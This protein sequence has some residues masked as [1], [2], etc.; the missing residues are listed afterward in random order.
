MENT[1][2]R[3]IAV[4]L[5]DKMFA[6][7]GSFTISLQKTGDVID[8]LAGRPKDFLTLEAVAREFGVTSA[9]IRR[10][11]IESGELTRTRLGFRRCDVERVKTR[12]LSA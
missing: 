12:E 1:T 2:H 3:E 5:I 11:Y 7:P 6:A 9:T 8:I 10:R 4:A